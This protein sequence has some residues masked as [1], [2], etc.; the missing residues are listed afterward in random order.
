MSRLT[1]DGTV[2]SVCDTKFPGANGDREKFIFPV[3][4]T[5][6]RI[7]NLA[8]LIHDDHTYIAYIHK[9]INIYIYIHTV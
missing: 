4:L 5:T 2:K 3:Q 8:R 6:S 9:Y 7:G 1:R